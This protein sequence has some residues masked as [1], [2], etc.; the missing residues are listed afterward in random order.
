MLDRHGLLKHHTVERPFAKDSISRW[1]HW[2]ALIEEKGTG[3]RYAI[4]SSSGPNGDNPTVQA[5]ASFYVPDSSA[6][7]TP[8]ETGVASAEP[9]GQRRN[10]LAAS[11]ACS[12]A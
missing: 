3:A 8:P 12:S 11:P 5:E 1:T 7:N 10:S 9:D 4:D 6:D 2:A